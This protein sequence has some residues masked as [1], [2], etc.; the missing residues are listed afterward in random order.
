MLI[1]PSGEVFS[2]KR[3]IAKTVVEMEAKKNAEV[4]FKS[5]INHPSRMEYMREFIRVLQRATA[6]LPP[7]GDNPKPKG[8][9]KSK[10]SNGT[11]MLYAYKCSPLM[12]SIFDRRS[13]C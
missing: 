11:H 8:K 1:T 4:L 10:A 2:L 3:E 9:G 12:L 6:P 13:S 5:T 7:K